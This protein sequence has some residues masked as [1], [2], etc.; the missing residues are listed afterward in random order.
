MTETSK[1]YNKALASLNDLI[2]EIMNDK[3]ILASSFL[4]P[5]RKTTNPEYTGKNKLL[6][7]PSSDRVNELLSNK[8]IPATLYNKL[9][10]FRDIDKKFE[11][12]GDLL[13]LIFNKT[14]SWSGNFRGE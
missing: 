10:T 8:A 14:E 9:L 11:S 3:G 2:V 6:R 1:E 7:N 5:F 4:S 13:K 12:Q